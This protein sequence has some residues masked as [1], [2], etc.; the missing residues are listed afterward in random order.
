MKKV[1]KYCVRTQ[2]DKINFLWYTITCT[3]NHKNMERGRIPPEEMKKFIKDDMLNAS[4]K[5]ENSED[6]DNEKKGLHIV[7]NK[8]LEQPK[9]FEFDLGDSPEEIK[10]DEAGP[11]TYGVKE[12][13][14]FPQNTKFVELPEEDEEKEQKVA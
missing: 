14:D 7:K 2:I 8:K 10:T 11:Q 12:Q 1:D 5:A 13:Q 9:E 3:F 4:Y 6:S